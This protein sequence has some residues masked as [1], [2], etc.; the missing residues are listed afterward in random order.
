MAEQD[1]LRRILEGDARKVAPAILGCTLECDGLSLRITEVEAY[2]YPGDSANHCFKGPTARNAAMWG[3]AGTAYVYLC[4]GMHALLNVVCQAEGEGAAV[5]IRSGDVCEG[6]ALALA[7]RGGRDDVAG[8]AKLTQ[9]LGI[10]CAD[11]GLDLLA[12]ES[13]LRLKPGV[14]PAR[15]AVG[16]RI[17][18]D[19]AALADRQACA[20]FA[21]AEATQ[22]SHRRKFE[23][24]LIGSASPAGFEPASPA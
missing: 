21:D 1:S 23:K 18:I 17:G 12:P 20:R 19:Y 16:A 13:R 8:P 7:R 5:L 6:H 14:R 9:A 4:Y 10:S 24:T 11:D 15:V 2:W 3:K 22:V